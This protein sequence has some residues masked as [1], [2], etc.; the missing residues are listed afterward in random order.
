MPCPRTSEL[1]NHLANR[2]RVL[3]LIQETGGDKRQITERAD[4]SRSSIDRDIRLLEEDGF[5]KKSNRQWVL[6][7]F[8][9]HA[10]QIFEAG[11]QITELKDWL[12]YVPP[13]MPMSF[14]QEGTIRRSGGIRPHKP[15]SHISQLIS[16]ASTLKIVTPIILEKSTETILSLDHH[17]KMHVEIIADSEVLTEWCEYNSDVFDLF[18]ENGSHSVKEI[19]EKPSFGLVFQDEETVCL[20]IFD[21]GNRLLGTITTNDPLSVIWARDEFNRLSQSGNTLQSKSEIADRKKVTQK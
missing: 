18:I 11:N 21:E 1:F 17:T 15:L 5:L 4:K 16:E 10:L 6:S 13:E 20:S 3:Q 9:R 7:T 2:G 19:Q 12:P 14:F 8:G